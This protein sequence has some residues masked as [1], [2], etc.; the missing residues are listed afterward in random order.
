VRPVVIA[1]V[2]KSNPAAAPEA[3]ASGKMAPVAPEHGDDKPK[4]RG[5]AGLLRFAR[6]D[7]TGSMGFAVTPADENT[8]I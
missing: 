8:A 5:E 2:A 7:G 1:S 6:N 4:R 3:A